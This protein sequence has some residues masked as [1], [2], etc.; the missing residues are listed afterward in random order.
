MELLQT[1]EYKEIKVE[2]Y[3]KGTDYLHNKTYLNGKLVCED[4]TY[5]PGR[6]T[7]IDSTE[8]MVGLLGFLTLRQ[9]DVEPSYFEAINAPELAEW[10]DKEDYSNSAQDIRMMIYD[11]ENSEDETY[12]KE[13][14]MT[15]D[16]ARI[17]EQYIKTY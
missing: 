3:Y 5:R 2:T 12:L 15:E 10:A 11:F 13:N 9:G 8:A 6:A 17:I 4:G 16:E 14:E 7:C 1:F